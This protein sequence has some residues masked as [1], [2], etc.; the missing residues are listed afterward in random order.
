LQK[1]QNKALIKFR[2]ILVRLKLSFCEG[3]EGS[4]ERQVVLSVLE[5]LGGVRG[6]RLVNLAQCS[7]L[8]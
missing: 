5:V 1:L 4:H 7:Q 8:D 3:K 6:R 2:A